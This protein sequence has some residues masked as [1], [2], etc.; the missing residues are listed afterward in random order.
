MRWDKTEYLLKGVYLGLLL[1]LA[2]HHPTW[3]DLGI[4]AGCT[5]GGL[6]IALVVSAIRKLRT[7]IRVH[8]H[9]LGFVLFLLLENPQAVYAGIVGGL[10]LGTAATLS[11][12]DEQTT[13]VLGSILGG[14]VLGFL[15]LVLRGVRRRDVRI[16]VGLALGVI[17]AAAAVTALGW[18]DE[19][20]ADLAVLGALLLFAIPGFYLLTFVSIAEESEME[21]AALCAALGIGLWALAH[22]A[23]TPLRSGVFLVPLVVYGVYIRFVLPKLRVFKHALRGLSYNQIGQYDRALASLGRALQL[24]PR[25]GLAREQLWE[26]HRKLDFDRVK[27]EPTILA[28]VNVNLCLERV[29]ALLLA[30]RPQEPQTKEALHLLQLVEHQRSDLA[31]MCAYW[32][33]V[34][35]CHRREYDEAA[36]N[37]QGL[38]SGDLPGDPRARRTVLFSGWQLAAALHPEMRR[39]VGEPLLQEPARRFEAIASVER[40]LA[41]LRERKA[42]ETAAWD[43]KRLLYAPLDEATYRQFVP[44]GKVV[45]EFDYGYVREMG[46]ALIEQ[47]AQWRRGEELLRIAARGLPLEATDLYVR[48]A[49]AHESASD[50]EGMWANFSNAV[51]VGKAA[52]V[53]NLTPEGRQ[54]LFATVK[55]IGDRAITENRLPVALDAY[56]FYS[57]REEAGIET[58]RTLAELFERSGDVWN[59]THCAEHALTFNATDADLLARKDRYYFSLPPAEVQARWE[60]VARWFDVDYVE[61][62]TKFLVEKGA[63]SLELIEW[64]SHLADL[65]AVAKPAGMRSLLLRARVKRLRGETAE[66]I[67]LLEKIRQNKPA[68]FGGEEE[69]DAWFLAHRLLGDF[70]LADRPADA[71]PCYAEF[72]KSNRAGADSAFK[73]GKAF[74]AVGDL[75]KAARFYEEVLTFPEHPLY[76]EAKDAIARLK[77]AGVARK[78]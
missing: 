48:I 6:A 8:G 51:Q 38:L 58:W 43:V 41:E 67:E 10:A 1:T 49:K 2:L 30:D 54:T 25:H 32:R 74:E 61:S 68:R 78:S 64:A 75:P 70:Y 42:D 71:I 47:A 31:P 63:G 59:A 72:R 4:V 53:A 45:T 15:F 13:L 34:A 22:E 37:L 17:L 57:Q 36:R 69:E 77:S 29:S 62:K 40:E 46:I 7:G 16:G 60:Q 73:L 9:F 52:G 27:N 65:L 28:N 19:Q 24:N 14:A 56:K 3:T 39:R 11:L 33:A 50:V 26:L 12:H 23:T 35:C 20:P 18:F 5:V 66:S 76:Y 21:M 55:A 44:E